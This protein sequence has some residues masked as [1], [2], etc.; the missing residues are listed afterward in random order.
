MARD[1]LITFLLASH[2]LRGRFYKSETRRVQHT[3]YEGASGRLNAP[4]GLEGGDFLPFLPCFET[5]S[6]SYEHPGQGG[7]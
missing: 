4:T 2:G 3:V 6:S 5:L 1:A 7:Q